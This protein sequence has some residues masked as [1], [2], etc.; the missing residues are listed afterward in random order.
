MR[1]LFSTLRDDGLS[2]SRLRGL[3][4]ALS[5]MF[6][7]AVE[8]G[9]L[10]S[11]P[12]QGLRIPAPPAMTRRNGR[13][14]SPPELAALLAA[15]PADWRLFFEFLVHTGLG[16]S[17]AMA[18]TWEDVDL[19]TARAEVRQ[20]STGERRGPSQRHAR[21]DI[22]LAGRHGRRLWAPRR[23]SHR[24][25]PEP[26]FA[27]APAPSLAPNVPTACSSRRVPERAGSAG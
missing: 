9:L 18:L 21:R 16:I 13:R 7:T 3:R 14:L 26:V 4:A 20:Q 1:E 11:N 23:D 25:D 6:A 15:L 24:G 27:T 10:R 8:D 5:A 12:V 17:E 22:P 2:T 19:A